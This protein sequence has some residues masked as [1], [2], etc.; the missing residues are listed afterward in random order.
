MNRLK[1]LIT[2]RMEKI[3][4]VDRKINDGYSYL[5]RSL[6]LVENSTHVLN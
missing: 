1:N 5:K 2:K 4:T 3:R 6:S